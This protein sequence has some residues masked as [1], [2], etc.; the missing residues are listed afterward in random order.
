MANAH[1]QIDTI[2][3]HNSLKDFLTAAVIERSSGYKPAGNPMQEL[4]ARQPRNP[5]A[6]LKQPQGIESI[7][8]KDINFR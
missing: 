3:N 1:E 7:P 5:L 4:Q 2:I 8:P 6:H